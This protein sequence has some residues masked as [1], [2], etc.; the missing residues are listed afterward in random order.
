MF[1]LSNR[2]WFIII[3]KKFEIGLEYK[4]WARSLDGVL[5]S[6]KVI[7][8]VFQ[9]YLKWVLRVF[10]GCLEIVSKIFW[11]LVWG[12]FKGVLI[13][14]QRHFEGVSKVFPPMFFRYVLRQLQICC[15]FRW[16][17]EWL[18]YVSIVFQDCLN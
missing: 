9:E 14:C 11:G 18:E 13:R 17:W 4:F 2:G 6:F 10:Q 7:C 12:C 16:C 8:W 1:F 15:N 3:D 5:K